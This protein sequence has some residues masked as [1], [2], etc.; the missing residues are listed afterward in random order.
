MIS[1]IQGD[2]KSGT[3]GAQIESVI[4]SGVRKLSEKHGGHDGQGPPA[5]RTPRYLVEEALRS[6]PPPGLVTG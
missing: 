3:N 4:A 1:G 5:S 6:W 2:L